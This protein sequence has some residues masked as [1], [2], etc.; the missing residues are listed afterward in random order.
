MLIFAVVGGDERGG[1]RE[2]Y[3]R[4]RRRCVS[5]GVATFLGLSTRMYVWGWRKDETKTR[6]NNSSVEITAVALRVPLPPN[7]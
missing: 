6:E 3:S 4:G 1:F 7:N 5:L 2:L